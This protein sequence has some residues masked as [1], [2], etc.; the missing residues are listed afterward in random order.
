MQRGEFYFTSTEVRY[1]TSF[2]KK[3]HH[4]LVH[5]LGRSA[6]QII[7]K[8]VFLC[9]NCLKSRYSAASQ[10]GRIEFSMISNRD[11]ENI[12]FNNAKELF[13]L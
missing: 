4:S 11:K 7:D 12:L 6:H 1:F 9:H 10:R 3:I 8:V 5:P 2:A 13:S